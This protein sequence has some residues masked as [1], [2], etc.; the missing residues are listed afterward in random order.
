[1]VGEKPQFQFRPWYYFPELIPTSEHPIVRN[2]DI[3]KTDF[4]STLDLIDN[5]IRKTVLLTTSEYTRVKKAPAMI[6]LADANTEPDQRLFNHSRLPVAVLLEGQFRSA[7][8]NRL[9]PRFTNEAA[10]GFREK[11][12]STKMIVIAD[13][14][15]IKNRYI[16][17]EGAVLPLG[18]D[19]YTQTM[20]ANKDL[21]LGA[22]NYL[23]G[24]EGLMAS[25][26]RNIKLRKL[27]VMKVKEERTKYQVINIVV[28]LLLLAAAGGVITLVRR[29][30]YRK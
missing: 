30:K 4:V 1:M 5:D 29:K 18:F 6:D 25:R 28:P 20:Y 12:D 19:Y 9:S 27:D 26:S 17:D 11:G 7:W 3:I 23:V 14:D 22:V 24:D 16:A 2:L 21:L 15:I 8:R 10:M 13:G